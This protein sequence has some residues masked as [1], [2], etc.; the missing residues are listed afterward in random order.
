MAPVYPA[1]GVMVVAKDSASRLARDL[2]NIR[3]DQVSR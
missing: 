3:E 2:V 1:P